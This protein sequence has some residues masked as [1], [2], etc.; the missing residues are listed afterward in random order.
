MILWP[1]GG[2]GNERHALRGALTHRTG[3]NVLLGHENARAQKDDGQMPKLQRKGDE[4]TFPGANP[5][6]PVSME[7]KMVHNRKNKKNE[8]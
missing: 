5:L 2:G 6:V 1:L 3:E 8:G 7:T 4:E